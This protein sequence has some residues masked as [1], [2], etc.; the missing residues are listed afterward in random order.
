MELRQATFGGVAAAVSAAVVLVGIDSTGTVAAV[1]FI[2]AVPGAS[3]LL[4]VVLWIAAGALVL[5]GLCWAVVTF[6]FPT[7]PPVLG[8]GLGIA[9]GGGLGAVVRLLVLEDTTDT[10]ETVSVD[11]STDEAAST[12]TPAD[13]FET[14]PD[15]LLYYDATGDGPVVRAVNDA[16]VET[17]DVAAT[18]VEGA[19]LRD[20]LLFQDTD[21]IVAAV[22]AGEA[23]DAVHTCETTDGDSSFRVRLAA[24]DAS[25]YVLYTEA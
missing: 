9:I 12:P 14:H 24:T 22:A 8:L 18:M 16:F 17:F 21:D 25:G 13:L 6:L 10:T 3:G 20:A 23:Y 2:L 7:V 5:G 15:P 1:P 11:T 19:P 4:G